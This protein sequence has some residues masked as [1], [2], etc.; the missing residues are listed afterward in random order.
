[1]VSRISH[2]FGLL[3]IAGFI[4][5]GCKGSSTDPNGNNNHVDIGDIIPPLHST[6]SYVKSQLD[7]SN[8]VIPGNTFPGHNAI[9]TDTGLSIQGKSHVYL[10]LDDADTCYYSYESSSDVSIYLQNPGYLQ[11]HSKGEST[12]ETLQTIVNL[13]FHNWITLP[14]ATKDTGRVVYNATNTINITG[15]LIA[16]KILAKADFIGDS[17]LTLFGGTILASKHCKLTITAVFDPVTY[18]GKTVTHTRDIWFVPKIGYIAKL[19]TR[20]NVPDIPV[21]V[22][23]SD[24]TA[25]EKTLV[26]YIL[27]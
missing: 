12:D 21:R 27:N 23:T 22:V 13:V 3:I 17:S 2:I 16:T 24:T 5:S 4:I 19:R 10:V 18:P 25:I 11:N 8:N 7:Q 20:T 1:M 26:S 9:V 15:D 6:Y 14:I